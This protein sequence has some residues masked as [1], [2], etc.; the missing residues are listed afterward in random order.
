MAAAAVGI[1]SLIVGLISASRANSAAQA[2][3][4]IADQQ[5]FEAKFYRQ[6]WENF[7]KDCELDHAAEI[8]SRSRS[9][10]RYA[11]TRNRMLV[12]TRKAF[13]Q[14]RRQV[15]DC[16]A[17]LCIGAFKQAQVQLAI[18]EA[19]AEVEMSDRAFRFEENRSI[20]LNQQLD[21]LLY[22]NHQLGRGMIVN[23]TAA[24]QLA[25]TQIA[26]IA[27]GAGALAG[28]GLSRGLRSLGGLVG[29][30]QGGS[31]TTVN[32][33]GSTQQSVQPSALT[34]VDN[35][36]YYSPGGNYYDVGGSTGSTYVAPSGPSNSVPDSF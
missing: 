9:V 17:T 19:N 31:Q 29:Q 28:Y 20:L 26:N 32:V 13:R 16:A 27:G 33:G 14:A 34:G 35:D 22:R 12:D 21:D 7:Y 15:S 10:P 24:S 6:I 23:A 36:A 18:A 25:A 8:C 11:A 2:Q 3:Q 4:A 1:G 30:Q 5:I